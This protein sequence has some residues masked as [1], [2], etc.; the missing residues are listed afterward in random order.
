[1]VIVLKFHNLIFKRIK[2]K[3]VLAAFLLVFALIT[4]NPIWINSHNS[5]L[6]FYLEATSSPMVIYLVIP[7][8]IVAIGYNFINDITSNYFVFIS[9]R[10]KNIK[11]AMYKYCLYEVYIAV[12]ISI[13][14]F[15]LANVIG[16][17]RGYSTAASIRH[18]YATNNFIFI[19]ARV[20]QVV[21]YILSIFFLL[22]ICQLILKKVSITFIFGMFYLALIFLS[23]QLSLK[24]LKEY[25]I[26]A[27]QELF[28]GIYSTTKNLVILPYLSLIW[29]I[30]EIIFSI[31]IVRV[32][33]NESN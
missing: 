5:F 31:L 15:L 28:Y 1:M 29:I 7:L 9:S 33:S 8:I 13:F 23:Y 21:L 4:M 25:P 22:N 30:I 16:W 27:G 10:Y 11:A 18:I 12:V 24:L 3:I 14:L 6:D 2:Y 17:M 19:I 20:W 26:I 32:I